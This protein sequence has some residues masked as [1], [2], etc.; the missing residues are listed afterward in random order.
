MTKLNM[1]ITV[2]DSEINGGS[3]GNTSASQ[4]RTGSNLAKLKYH[5]L[6]SFGSK[7]VSLKSQNN[8]NF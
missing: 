4:S 1:L 7:K 6:S 3:E 8:D 2:I 5:V